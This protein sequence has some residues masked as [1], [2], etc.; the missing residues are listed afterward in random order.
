MHIGEYSLPVV[1]GA[2]TEKGD[3]IVR[4]WITRSEVYLTPQFTYTQLWYWVSEGTAVATGDNFVAF[5]CKYLLG[6]AGWPVWPVS[7]QLGDFH[8]LVSFPCT[9]LRNT[10]NKNQTA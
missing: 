7:D 1:T 4:A 9:F 10:I 6:F 8:V 3:G 2:E 5:C